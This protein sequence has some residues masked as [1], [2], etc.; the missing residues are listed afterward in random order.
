MSYY[1]I[2]E[3]PL[4]PPEPKARE[5]YR[6]AMCGCVIYEGDEYWDIPGYGQCCETCIDEAHHYDAEIEYPDEE[7]D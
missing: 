1:N 6:C 3:R 7:D 5:V 4:D 2:P